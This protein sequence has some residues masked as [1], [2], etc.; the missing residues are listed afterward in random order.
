MVGAIFSKILPDWLL[1]SSLV[2]LLAFTS[3]RTLAKGIS[4]YQKETKYFEDLKKSELSKALATEHDNE[5]EDEKV[6]LLDQIRSDE[7]QQEMIREQAEPLVSTASSSKPEVDPELQALLDS[8]R[9]TPWEKVRM[10]T[11]MIVAVI[12]LNLAKGGS[13]SFPSPLGIKCGSWG[14]WGMTGLVFLLIILVSIRMRT[15]LIEKWRLKRRLNYRYVEGDVEW[16]PRNTIIYPCIC[17]FAG[18]FAGLFGVGGGIVKGPL[19]LEMGVNPLVASGTV[20]VMI[21][22]TSGQYW[23]RLFR[24]ALP[25]PPPP[26]SLTLLL[27]SLVLLCLAL[28]LPCFETQWLPRRCSWRLARSPGTMHSSSSASDSAARLWDSWAWVT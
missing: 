28:P 25:S 10:V 24:H 13:G 21:M 7:E 18:F 19:M 22:Y 23:H 15:M 27:L 4:Q 11:A 3:Q 14:Y 17:F 2:V 1:V 26:S 12:I 5:E 8:E 9:E 20:A 6:G 16:T